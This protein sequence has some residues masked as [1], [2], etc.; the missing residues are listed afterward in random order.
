M[1][2]RGGFFKSKWAY[3]IWFAIYFSIAVL[4]F[5]CF[6]N[7]IWLCVL[8]SSILYGGSI[9][10]A[11][12]SLGEILLRLTEGLN[13]IETQ[14]DKDY[15]LPIFEDVYTDALSFTPSLNK[16]IKLYVLETMTV[17]AFAIGRK[18]I[19]VTR[20]AIN[21]FSRDELKG[22]LSHEFGHMA[23]GDT[24][25]LLFNVVGNGF[26]SIIVLILRFIMLFIQN[27]MLALTKKNLIM[28]IF[29]FVSFVCRLFVDISIFTFIFSGNIILALNSRYCESLA[30]EFAFQ[31]GYGFEL[32]EALYL[33]NK[34]SMSSKATIKERLMSS[35]PH[36]TSRIERL[37]TLGA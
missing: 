7:N 25:A 11:L 4:I 27:L 34:I 15:L 31:I 17:N 24:K 30:D 14:E 29:A 1:K 12:S 13:K 18:T 6:E 19:A 35:H 26:F 22:I 37:E 9:G 28:I 10:L 20:G 36:T 8:Y 3:L 2:K 16:N 32:K 33:L 5:K 23:N 21:T